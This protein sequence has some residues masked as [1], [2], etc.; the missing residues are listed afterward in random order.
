M[1]RLNVA[2]Q[3]NQVGYITS[4]VEQLDL[5]NGTAPADADAATAGTLLVTIPLTFPSWDDGVSGTAVLKT[6]YAG[7]AIADGTVGY[8]RLTTSDRTKCIQGSAGISD[9]AD[10]VIDKLN[11]SSS[12]VVTLTTCNIIMPEL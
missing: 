9:S 6:S 8:G 1:A 10:F 5:Y 12:E 3:N 4:T 11:F 7:T 2:L